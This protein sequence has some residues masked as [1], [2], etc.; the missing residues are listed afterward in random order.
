MTKQVIQNAR[1][2][3]AAA[4]F[5]GV[6][7]APPYVP[8]VCIV[9]LALRFRAWEALFIGL[10]CDFVWLPQSPYHALPLFT[11]A[12]MAIVWVL[13]PLRVQLLH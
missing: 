5:V 4:G 1:Y 7:I 10:L 11:L 9:L 6:F 12:A 13:E 2:L 8:F 3:L